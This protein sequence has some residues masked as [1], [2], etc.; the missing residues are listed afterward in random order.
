MRVRDELQA[1]Q[2]AACLH[3]VIGFKLKRLAV[4]VLVGHHLVEYGDT[5]GPHKGPGKTA[6]VHP[7]LR[8]EKHGH[9]GAVSRPI[10]IDVNHDV[11]LVTSWVGV[12][13]WRDEA[14]IGLLLAREVRQ[15]END[16]VSVHQS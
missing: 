14:L 12:K 8:S 10:T 16:S 6:V 5:H 11:H 7:H 1:A 2:N 4:V 13:S 15:L 9:V 3:V